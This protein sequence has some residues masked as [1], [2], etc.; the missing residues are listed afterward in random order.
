MS[1]AKETKTEFVGTYFEKESVLRLVAV[2]KVFSWIIL[3]AYILS[4]SFAL[5]QFI[6]QFA[7]GLFFNKGMGAGDVL[8]MFSPYLLQPVPGFVYFAVLQA[9]SSGLLILLDVEDNTRRAARK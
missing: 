2:V 4:T 8:N 7:S 1:E 9:V 5:A 6:P 3:V